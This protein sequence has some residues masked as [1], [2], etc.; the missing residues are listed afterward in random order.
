MNRRTDPPST[1]I[2][3]DAAFTRMEHDLFQRIAADEAAPMVRPVPV[4]PSTSKPAKRMTRRRWVGVMAAAA[5]VTIVTMLTS[6]LVGPNAATAEAAEALRS[7]ATTTITT[8]DPVVGP[9][10]Y[11]AVDTTEAA[12]GSYVDFAI[13][14]GQRAVLYVPF[15][16]DDVWVESRQTLPAGE[17]YGNVEKAQV[18]IDRLS[19]NPGNG[20]IVLRD[21]QAGQFIE[22]GDRSG[23]QIALLPTDSNELLTYLYDQVQAEGSSRSTDEHVFMDISDLL[24][25]GLVPAAV[26]ASLYDVLARV[27]GVYLSDGQANLDGRTGV[28][29]SRKS[30]DSYIEQI[31]IDPLTGLVIGMRTLTIEADGYFPAGTVTQLTSVKTLVVGDAPP[32]PFRE[33][34][35]PG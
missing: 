4:R 9:G 1:L 18:E 3:D 27:P 25:T 14:V 23:S 21:G 33:Q 35:P 19:S 10:E 7:A 30:S 15:D 34:S 24:R 12:T 28:G 32:G 26:R 2:P 31:I 13:Q 8:S 11:L 17:T 6:N 20:D 16:R 5:A 22:Y 29:I